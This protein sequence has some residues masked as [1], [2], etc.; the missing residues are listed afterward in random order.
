MLSRAKI[1]LFIN[2]SADHGSKT[3]LCKSYIDFNP[4]LL[5]LKIETLKLC[6]PFLL[7]LFQHIKFSEVSGNLHFRNFYIKHECRTVYSCN[8][9]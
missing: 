8:V 2:R 4:I 5:H 1:L 3:Q 7:H 6:I 9:F